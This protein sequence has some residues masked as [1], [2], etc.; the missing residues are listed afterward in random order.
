MVL[1]ATFVMMSHCLCPVC[2]DVSRH[3]WLTKERIQLLDDLGFQ[4][5]VKK[6]RTA[7][8][9]WEAHIALLRKAQALHQTEDYKNLQLSHF[10]SDPTFLSSVKT[11]LEVVTK[12]DLGIK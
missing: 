12:G 10:Q 8:Q 5:S 2:M 6:K 3:P 7:A 11:Y 1:I 4:W 9:Q